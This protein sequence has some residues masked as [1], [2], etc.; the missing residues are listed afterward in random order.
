MNRSFYLAAAAAIS[1]TSF[2]SGATTS[3]NAA[4]CYYGIYMDGRGMLGMDSNATAAKRST[5]CTRARRRC[6]RTLERHRK[7][8]QKLPRHTPRQ[9][10]CERYGA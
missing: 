1:I 3:A 2:V 5:A 7:S 8:G 6:N 10:R 4:T 9:I